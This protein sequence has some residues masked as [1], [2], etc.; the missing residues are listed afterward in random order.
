MISGSVAANNAHTIGQ[1]GHGDD[2]SGSRAPA[3]SGCWGCGAPA[4]Y[5][6]GLYPLCERC[7]QALAEAGG[8]P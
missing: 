1:P 5:T 8:A 6:C 3:F 4:D 2:V 7:C